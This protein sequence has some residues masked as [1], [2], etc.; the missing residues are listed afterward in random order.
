VIWIT[1]RTEAARKSWNRPNREKVVRRKEAGTADE[2]KRILAGKP[3]PARSHPQTQGSHDPRQP[4][5][6]RPSS[7]PRCWDAESAD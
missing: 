4:G 2:A 3:A 7:A 6:Q 1:Q 5:A